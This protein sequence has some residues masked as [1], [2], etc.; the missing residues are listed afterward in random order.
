M[1][2]ST[3]VYIFMD[4]GATHKSIGS[5][6]SCGQ[7]RSGSSVPLLCLRL[8]FPEGW[9]ARDGLC[10]ALH[11]FSC[12]GETWQLYLGAVCTG[13]SGVP[14]AVSG[15]LSPERSCS[16]IEPRIACWRL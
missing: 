6:L 2:V 14:C 13:S 9:E 7:L 4:V 10:E 5:E 8:P 1:C 16:V 12:L 15:L 3:P 11:L